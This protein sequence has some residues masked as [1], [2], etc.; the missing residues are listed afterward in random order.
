MPQRPRAHLSRTEGACSALPLRAGAPVES[1]SQQS[2][3]V[4]M[5][6]V[7]A[8]LPSEWINSLAQLQF[9]FAK[10]RTLTRT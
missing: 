8:H 7:S 9:L 5:D 4:K 6:L 2:H 10:R 3:H 1:P